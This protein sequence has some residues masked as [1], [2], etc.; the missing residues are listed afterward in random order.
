MRI[1]LVS[2]SKLKMDYLCKARDLYS[3]STLFTKA[4]AYIEQGNYDQWFILS[5]KHGLLHPVVRV[6][7]YETTLH[8]MNVMEVKEWSEEVFASLMVHKPTE[9]DIYAGER[10]RRYLIPLLRDA[11]IR[12][13]VPLEGMEIGQQLQYYTEAARATLPKQ[14]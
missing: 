1:A 8:K 11:G 7:P 10:Y 2:C 13:K 5:A 3:K 14:E 6:A 4:V 9:V 12:V